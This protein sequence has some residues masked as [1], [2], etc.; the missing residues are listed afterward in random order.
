MTTVELGR[1]QLDVALAEA[2]L[3][4]AVM[5]LFHLTGDERWLGDPFRPRRD[6]R[7]I[8]DERA[9]FDDEIA[10][11]IRTALADELERG[12]AAAIAAPDDDL[13]HRMMC[14][15]MGEEI[16]PAYAPMMR[17]DLG[18]Q[19]RDP[20]WTGRAAP[21]PE[22]LDGR[23]VVVIG[24]GASGIG[25]GYRLLQLG[26]PF[27]IVERAADVGGTWRDNTYPGCG[28]DTPNHAY[29]YSMG[30]RYPWSRN[31]SPQPELLDYL[32]GCADEFGIRAHVRFEHEVVGTRWDDTAKRWTVTASTPY[33]ERELTGTDL[34][35]AIGQFGIP[36][37]P[38]F[39]GMD[40]FA[41]EMFHTTAWPDDL[42][43]A[44]KRVAII[45]TGASAMQIVP[46]IAS[47]VGHLSVFQRSAQWARPIPRYHD[48][49]GAGAQW[50]L[51]N[52][53]FYAQWFRFTMLWR[54]GDGLL[55]FLRKD[56]E[57]AHPERSLNRVNEKHRVE[58]VDYIE[59][60]LE[61]RPDLIEAC[62][63]TYPPYG[64]RILLDNGWYRTLLRDN[65]DLVTDR[66]ERIEPGGV[67]T[68]DG[69]LHGADV[70]VLSTGFRMTDMARAVRPVGRDGITL[71]EVWGDDDATAHLGITVPGFPNLFLMQG[72]STGLGHGGSAIFQAESQTRFITDAI[73]RMIE[74]EI[75][76]IEPTRAAHDAF[77]A[78]VDR[79]HAQMIWSHP[80]MSTYYRNSHGRVVSVTPFSILEYWRMTHDIDLD[81]YVV[82]P[83]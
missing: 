27:T 16:D 58:M 64:K 55:P 38:H 83:R 42:D 33:G 61:G 32:R 53:P 76:A 36:S 63:P 29:S 31:F 74:S 78:E 35:V 57:W 80:G 25:L 26:I 20:A 66:I 19:P 51:A 50:L 47:E 6:V 54:Y 46:S 10:A 30:R 14:W 81:D 5:C 45:G 73:V 39:E 65:V 9:G 2:D 7:L 23:H 34:V 22:R 13:M 12:A 49:I 41:G 56:P 71:G 82:T 70:I 67:R 68:A 28:V 24:A 21:P 75:A 11:E 44:G 60:E 40:D 1:E 77:V 4:V 43:I 37:V 79:R 17:E 69:R 3:R 62:T 52:V 72:P 15:C 48:L 8:S 59:S 18:F